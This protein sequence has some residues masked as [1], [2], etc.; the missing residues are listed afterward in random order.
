M[1]EQP[2]FDYGDFGPNYVKPEGMDAALAVLVQRRGATRRWASF[3]ARANGREANFMAHLAVA[4]SLEH[5][6]ELDVAREAAKESDRRES[7]MIGLTR[8]ITASA[9]VTT[10]AALASAWA[11]W[12]MANH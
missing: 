10:V 6:A 8:A 1:D 7:T 3:I 5:Q 2:G 4:M 12:A 9:I 11:A